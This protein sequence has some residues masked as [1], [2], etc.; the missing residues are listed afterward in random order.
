RDKYQNIQAPAYFLTGWYDNLVHETWNNFVGFREE[1]G[2]T[3]VRRG[4]KII[5]GPWVH[6]AMAPDKTWPVNFGP[7]AAV[8]LNDL[9]VRWYDYWLKG[10][11][12]GF[13]QEA[14]IRLFVMG[15]NQWRSEQEWPLRR[16]KWTPFYLSSAGK[17]N[18]AEGD[19]RLGA[20]PASSS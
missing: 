15:A 16:T 18:T 11:P 20:S 5:V 7:E 13:E 17:A 6:G 9:H 12:R 3:E 2:S 8:S 10:E 1:G 14:P 19:G 4:T